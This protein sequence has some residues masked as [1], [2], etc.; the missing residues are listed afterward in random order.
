MASLRTLNVQGRH[1]PEGT[2]AEPEPKDQHGI[3]QT[4]ADD[5]AH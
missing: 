3:R 5:G 1:L 2:S 4:T